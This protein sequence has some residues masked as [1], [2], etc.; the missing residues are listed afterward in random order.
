MGETFISSG[1]NKKGKVLK[2]K[3]NRSMGIP[4]GLSF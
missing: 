1:V 4:K 2:I 3:E